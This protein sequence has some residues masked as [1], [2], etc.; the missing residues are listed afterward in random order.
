MSRPLAFCVLLLIAGC[1]TKPQQK[2]PAEPSMRAMGKN[3]V[4]EETRSD[5]TIGT[6]VRRQLDLASSED[7]AGVTVEV[8]D[9]IVTLR[10]TVSRLPVAFRAEAAAHAVSGVKAVRNLLQ[11]ARQPLTP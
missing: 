4:P 5:E 11:V 2:T 10:G 8:Q 9:G 6:E 3:I 1:A 7:M